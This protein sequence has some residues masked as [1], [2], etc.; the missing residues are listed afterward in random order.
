VQVPGVTVNDFPASII[1]DGNETKQLDGLAM[2]ETRYDVFMPLVIEAWS[3]ERGSPHISTVISQ[4]LAN[5]EK[6]MMVNPNRGTHDVSGKKLALDTQIRGNE[7]ILAQDEE[8]YGGVRVL[9]EVRYR[10]LIGD[11]FSC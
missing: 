1:I 4:L 2:N 7:P 8:P 3:K 5:I 10:H 11:P 9:F 6:A